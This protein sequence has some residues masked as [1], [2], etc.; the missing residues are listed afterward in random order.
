MYNLPQNENVQENYENMVLTIQS[1]FED[2][3][4]IYANLANISSVINVYVNRI[5]WV[6][7]YLLIEDELVLG[8]FQGRPACTRI[9]PGNGVCGRS[10]L[11]KKTFVVDNVH[12]F[13]GHIACDSNTNSEIVIP[14]YKNNEIWGV[15][16][17]DSPELN[18][19]TDLEKLYL[20]KIAVILSDFLSC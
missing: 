11:E 5:N 3:K 2:E 14:I 7:F 20:E 16:D 17:V 4:N 15:L 12:D 9:K 8:P 19:F 1:M 6:G 18:R 13:P 10:A